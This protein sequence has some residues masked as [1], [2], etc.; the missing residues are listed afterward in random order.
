MRPFWPVHKVVDRLA[1]VALLT[2]LLLAFLSWSF[3]ASAQSAPK[4][5]LSAA[6]NNSTLVLAGSSTVKMI[7]VVNTTATIYYF[8]LYSKATAPTCGTD[9]PQL[10]FAV[11]ALATGG[12]PIQVPIPDG[13]MFPLGI[14]FCLTAGIADNDNTAAATGVTI[15]LG[16]SRR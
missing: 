3:P 13:L 7:N 12:P 6:T 15:N 8:K 16:I 9:V 14:G 1:S 2:L 10:T 5:Y 11:P 4:H